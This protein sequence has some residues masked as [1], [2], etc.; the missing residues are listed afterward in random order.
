[1]FEPLFL[2]ADCTHLGKAAASGEPT[3][4]EETTLSGETNFSKETILSDEM[5]HSLS[6]ET[7]LPAETILS[8]KNY[9]SRRKDPFQGSHFPFRI[10]FPFTRHS[11]QEGTKLSK[12]MN[13]SKET[14]LSKDTTVAAFSFLS[15]VQVPPRDSS[16]RYPGALKRI[17]VISFV[18]SIATEAQTQNGVPRPPRKK[19]PPRK[20]QPLS[21]PRT[22]R[23]VPTLGL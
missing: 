1:V 15:G 20:C 2:T 5:T 13:L 14:A 16:V 11:L 3:L 10:R 21:Q 18:L 12:E 23:A 6:R 7:T 22:F 9:L 17:Q 8:E 4:S 19:A